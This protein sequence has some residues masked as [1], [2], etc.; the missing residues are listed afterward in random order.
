MPHQERRSRSSAESVR[1][2][3]GVRVLRKLQ[4]EERHGPDATAADGLYDPGGAAARPAR[5]RAMADAAAGALPDDWR[6]ARA[7][8]WRRAGRAGAGCPRR[9]D[10]GRRTRA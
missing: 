7:W 4:G 3:Q 10:D 9:I 8:V 6:A 5:L 1:L 2:C